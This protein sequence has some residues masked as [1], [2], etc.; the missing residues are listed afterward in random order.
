MG[1][2][3]LLDRRHPPLPPVLALQQ[4]AQSI[5][6]RVPQPVRTLRPDDVA[7]GG[8]THA[9][10]RGIDRLR[11][12]SITARRGALPSRG[13]TLLLGVANQAVYRF[14]LLDQIEAGREY[15][16]PRPPRP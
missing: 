9:G 16:H 3:T 4:F 13:P 10:N 1:G 14:D 12:A 5:A 2:G 11:P 8:A 15:M 6:Q 7:R